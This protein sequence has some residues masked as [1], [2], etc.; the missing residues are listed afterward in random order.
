[1]EIVS[2]GSKSV[3]KRAVHIN[4]TMIFWLFVIWSVF[5]FIL[6][7]L[8]CIFRSGHWE[9]HSSLVWGTFCT[10][11]GFGAVAVYLLA[12]LLREKNI[13]LQ[14]A[15]FMLSGALVE[16][17]TSWIQE[18]CFGSTSWDYSG[19]FFNIGGRVSLQMTLIWGVLGI[20]FSKLLYPVLKKLFSRQLPKLWRMITLACAVFMVINAA[21]S[22]AAVLRW[23]QRQAGFETEHPVAVFFDQHFDNRWMEHHYPNM[24]FGD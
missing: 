9:S 22:C 10:V 24:K 3:S 19:H 13:L 23:S 7:G 12:D 16:Y 6:E 15:A 4:V 2:S 8:W 14:S 18:F 20:A 11:Y 21:V 5:G 1:M 17:F